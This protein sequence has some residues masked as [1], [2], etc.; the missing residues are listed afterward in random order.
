MGLR[1]PARTGLVAL[2][3]AAGALARWGVTGSAPDDPHAFPVTTFAVNVLGAALL[4]YLVGRLPVTGPRSEGAR[5]LLGTGFLGA[6]TTFSAFA[7]ELARGAPPV[8]AVLTVVAGVV[9]AVVGLAAG[10]MA[11]RE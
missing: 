8:Y 7:L 4:G 5:L 10:A 9:A 1:T 3:G 11:V 6:F 2:G